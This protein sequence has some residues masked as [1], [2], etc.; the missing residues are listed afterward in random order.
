MK[1]FRELV[2]R[3][4][5]LFNKQRKDRELDEEIESHVQM[6][7]E[8]NLRLGMTAEE[9]RRQAM[10]QLGGIESTKEAYRDQRGLPI[11]ETLWQDVRFGT[12]MLSNN[13]GF[14]AVAVLTLVLGIGANTA[15]F[16]VVNGV[17]LKPLPYEKPGQLVQVWEAPQ[18]GKWDAI[19]PGAF[20]DWKEGG[21]SL[22]A[23]S[24]VNGAVMNLAGEGHPERL[25]G[26]MV[27]ASYLQVL[28]LQ[29]VL[30]R[31]FLPDEDK[32]GHD[33]KVVV[34][35]HGLWQRYFGADPSVIARAIRLNGEQRTVIGVLPPKAALSGW[36]LQDDWQFLIP[37]AF[38]PDVSP[39]T[40]EDH[41]YAVVAR[42]KPTATLEQ[43]QAELSAIKQRMQSLYPKWK[44]NWGVM[45]VP[46][47]EQIT[48]NVKPTLLVLM[49]AVGLVPLI[50][51][52]NVANLLLAKAAS[53]Q[54]EM[55]IRAA[56]GA[57]RWRVI[58]QVLT[59]S[60]LLALLGGLLGV[61]LSWLGVEVLSQWSGATLPRVEE[62]ALDARV[63]AFSLLASIGTGLLFG[64]VP[65]LRVS[66]PDLNDTLK[67][68]GRGS[69]GS[70]SRVRSGIIV[71][72]VALALMLLAGAGLLVRS[73]FRLL[74]VDPG[75]DPRNTLTMDLSVPSARYPSDDDRARFFQQICERL[76]AVPGVEAAGRAS[77][78]PMLGWSSETNVKVPGRANHPEP[79]Y[80][81]RWDSAAG[82]Y[83]NALGIPLL[84]GRNFTARDNSRSAPPVVVVN[85]A[86]AAK[87]FPNEDP[88]GK[89]LRF[90]NCWSVG[91]IKHLSAVN[92]PRAEEIGVDLRVLGFALCVSLAAGVAFGLVPALQSS[93]PN[94]NDMLKEGARSSGA[95]PRNRFQSG[96]IV[97]EVALSLILLVGAGLLLNSFV[98]LSNIP[99]GVN[100]RNVLTMQVAL[101]D[102]KYLDSERR[103]AFFE[104]A[105]E[106]IENL[107]GVEAAGVTGTMPMAG[108]W[109]NTT[110]SIIGRAGQPAVGYNTD[111]DF[112]TPDYFRA[113]GIPL[114]KGRGF[115]MRDKVGAPGV[116][117]INEALAREHFPNE[118]P[119]GKR[120]HLELF[121]GKIDAGWEIVGIVGNV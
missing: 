41:R 100:T 8:D 106:R 6:H 1:R 84:R 51:C 96:L 17:L 77:S 18:P 25:S 99:S 80:S 45:V 58:R 40:R 53:R 101:S 46:L 15:I 5:G 72:E 81:A 111:F 49:G 119:L 105:L 12:R 82:N 21:T 91:V 68:G 73:F 52:A 28:R 92:L 61:G 86:L 70:H 10:I 71:A 2:L 104:R 22:E 57:S 27:S 43:A 121:T 39:T 75:F 19:S 116:V 118:E 7:I 59:E 14:T 74:N 16:S 95:G 20:T 31:G 63:L 36:P 94:L 66:A 83:F 89:R 85:E 23:L 13:P 24:L 69:T 34:I 48:G 11:L 37:F 29:P 55:A 56:L 115:T 110:F 87:I 90:W 9:A 62:I 103:A 108:W 3:F 112:C 93:R 35:A 26:L 47:R 44:E 107:P 30:G 67:E 78:L 4:G 54:K 76:E 113:A 114:V 120:I 109:Q 42:L 64:L 117:I 60:S 65:A 32:P 97:A 102:K 33:N 88:L 98:R 38:P 50:A 79:G